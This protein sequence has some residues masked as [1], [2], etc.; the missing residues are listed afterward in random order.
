MRAA[1]GRRH[2]GEVEIVIPAYNEQRRITGTIRAFVD[3]FVGSGVDA[4]ICVVD[5]G[6]IDR[7]ADTVDAAVDG[8][9]PVTLM[10]C[11][12]QGKGAAVR[13][14]VLTS[15]AR[16]VGYCDSDTATPAETLNQILPL[17]RGGHPVVIGS[18]RCSGARY[19]EHPPLVRRFGG[20]VFR[21][22]AAIAVPGVADT[23]CGFKFFDAVA[24][25]RLFSA[26]QLDGFAFDVEVLRVAQ[27]CGFPIVEVPVHWTPVRGSTLRL[28]D[29]IRAVSDLRRVI[30]IATPAIAAA[31]FASDG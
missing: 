23:Q 24:A 21:T 29:G 2:A 30:R 20:W 7:T 3:Y 8:R 28:T 10:G 19:V 12:Q 26:V 27:L 25:R 17:L 11:S 18:R 6:S 15:Q 13:R 5:N 9:I 22:G 4:S 16:Y 1:A 31:G 14:G